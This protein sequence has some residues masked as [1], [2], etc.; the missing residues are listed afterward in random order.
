[1]S[2]IQVYSRNVCGVSR[3]YAANPDQ[4]LALQTLTSGA[5]L[6]DAHLRA[7]VAL[8]F[9]IE[10]VPDPRGNLHPVMSAALASAGFPQR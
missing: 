5:T 3:T 10:Q 2:T 7:L 1:M 6:S 4:A 8:G 9:T